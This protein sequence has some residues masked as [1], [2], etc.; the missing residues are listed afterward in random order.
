MNSRLT[1]HLATFGLALLGLAACSPGSPTDE[2]PVE[3]AEPA[4]DPI[5]G[6][7]VDK[8]DP[9][10][11]LMKAE[12]GNSGW[13]CTGTVIAKRLVLTAAHCVEE[14]D[15]GTKMRIMFGT[16]EST[17][18]ASD[19]IA[20]TEWHHDPGYMA[21]NNIAAGHD[22][23]VLILAQDAP[24]A[25]LLINHAA[26]TSA[27][28]GSPVH[29]VGYG[30]DDGQSGTGAGTKREIFTKLHS[31]EQGVANIGRP[32][33]TT[34][35]GDSGGPSFMSIGGQDVIVGITSYGEAGCVDYGSVT[36]VDLSASWID[37]YIAA[38]G[39][40]GGGGTCTPACSGRACGDDGCGGVCGACASGSSCTSAGQCEAKPPP[41][42]PP[43]GGCAES[44]P[45]DER[46]SANALCASGMMTG[47][48]STEYDSDWYTWKVPAK[49]TYTV[50]L[51][52]SH[53][54][55]MTLY[56]IV[57]GSLYEITSAFDEI[58]K[59]TPDGGLYY[60]EVW[61]GNGDYSP[62]DEYSVSVAVK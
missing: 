7:S 53:E 60:L 39:G 18:K 12:S 56:K 5:I 50:D 20:V 8:G 42:P 29:V 2:A 54:Y 35:Q 21:T 30:N 4:A 43:S 22:A 16:S 32:G 44:E 33:Q 41:P 38:N 15:A 9:S 40:G 51:I 47:R 46:S 1:T 31:L 58:Q 52:T 48:I 3:A 26:L 23:A 11:V 27:M 34:C 36:R 25:P 59:Q 37:P 17:A 28:V 55:V 49:A 57:N 13:W 45:N 10:V 24:V 62:T 61:G 14:A 6:G 19:Y